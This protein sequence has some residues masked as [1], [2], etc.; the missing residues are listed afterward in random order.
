MC[1]LGRKIIW[2]MAISAQRK[3]T[4]IECYQFAIGAIKSAIS[5][6]PSLIPIVLHAEAFRHLPEKLSRLST[7]GVHFVQHNLSFQDRIVKYGEK[8]NPWLYPHFLFNLG[9]YYRLDIPYV[10]DRVIASLALS[11]SS[12]V[13][14]DYVL[15]TDTDIL[16]LK[17]FNECSLP[18]PSVMMLGGEDVKGKMANTGIRC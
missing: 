18:K 1:I 16:F 5:N 2:F 10:I 13:D 12:Q 14:T 9:A 6:A 11:N 7:N 8:D 15:Y 3:E 17:D 4:A